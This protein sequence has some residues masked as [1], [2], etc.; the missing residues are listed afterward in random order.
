MHL[1]LVAIWQQSP[2]QGLAGTLWQLQLGSVAIRHTQA[3][4]G[5]IQHLYLRLIGVPWS[6]D[7]VQHNFQC[8]VSW[9]KTS[10]RGT[11]TLLGVLG[12]LGL[13]NLNINRNQNSKLPEID[14][15]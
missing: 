1:H 2:E 13:H 7:P 4:S 9:H 5:C 15:N 11:K 6:S 10:Q 14:G 8:P 3:L 12:V